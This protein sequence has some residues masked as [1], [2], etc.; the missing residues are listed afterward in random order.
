[1]TIDLSHIT[2]ENLLEFS[3][4]LPEDNVVYFL[5]YT[6]KN[7]SE[8]A[9]ECGVSYSKVANI[10]RKLEGKELHFEYFDNQSRR[11]RNKCENTKQIIRALIR[12]EKQSDIA[13]RL[14]VTRQAVSFVKRKYVDGND[15]CVKAITAE[16]FLNENT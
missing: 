5:K 12:G 4:G 7:I 6:S 1:M 8:I 11:L 16:E 10:K 2:A 3:R 9:R 15:D 14:G 13:R